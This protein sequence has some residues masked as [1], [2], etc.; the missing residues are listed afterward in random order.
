MNLEPSSQLN[1]FSH[2]EEFQKLI[3]LYKNNNLPNKILFSGEKGI[4][5]CTLAYHLINYITFYISQNH[6]TGVTP[7]HLI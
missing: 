3:N 7:L 4:G 1:L 6:L 2:K 5:K